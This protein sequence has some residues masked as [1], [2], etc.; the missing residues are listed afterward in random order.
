M[1]HC[2]IRN[3]LNNEVEEFKKEFDTQVV[4]ISQKYEDEIIRRHVEHKTRQRYQRCCCCLFKPKITP[5]NKG[6]RSEGYQYNSVEGLDHLKSYN[7]TPSS[8]VFHMNGIHS[9]RESPNQQQR[10]TQSQPTLRKHVVQI[11]PPSKSCAMLRHTNKPELIK[12]ESL[13]EEEHAQSVPT[14]RD[15]E[16]TK[17]YKTAT[18]KSCSALRHRNNYNYNTDKNKQTEPAAN[19]NDDITVEDIE[20]NVE[21]IED[22]VEQ[23]EVE[24]NISQSTSQTN[25]KEDPPQSTSQAS[26]KEEPP[27]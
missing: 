19:I 7:C 25:L 6:D 24:E 11:E 9:S 5:S 18:T 10:R 21:D 26:L 1:D 3:E 13:D 20:D 12:E 4:S 22:N 2:T 15:V 17:A 16:Q 8:S 27:I 14:L 23:N